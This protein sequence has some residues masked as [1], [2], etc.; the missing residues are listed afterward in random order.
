M[1]YEVSEEILKCHEECLEQNV[2]KRTLITLSLSY[3][4]YVF[5]ISPIIK[6]DQ[7]QD[8]NAKN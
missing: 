4:P 1:L 3:F 7:F 8:S 2:I 6:D 5:F